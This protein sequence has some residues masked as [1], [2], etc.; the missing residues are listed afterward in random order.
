MIW[1]MVKSSPGGGRGGG[2]RFETTPSLGLSL[3]QEKMRY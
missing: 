1:N 2:F 3:I